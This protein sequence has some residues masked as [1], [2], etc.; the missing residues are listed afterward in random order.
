MNGLAQNFGT[1]LN[2]IARHDGGE[3]LYLK[4]YG[5]LSVPVGVEP[6]GSAECMIAEEGEDA[7]MNP[8]SAVRVTSFGLEAEYGSLLVLAKPQGSEHGF[9]RVVRNPLPV[10]VWRHVCPFRRSR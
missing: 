9:E 8:S 5:R 6:Q 10:A 2:E 3:I 4:L 1:R 7:A